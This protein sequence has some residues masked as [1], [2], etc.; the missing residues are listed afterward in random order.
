MFY[1]KAKKNIKF[2]ILLCERLIDEYETEKT[3][4]PSCKNDVIEEISKLLN[5]SKKELNEWEADINH[6]RIA[7]SLLANTCYDLLASGNYHIYTGM[8]NPMKCGS[9]M[10]KVYLR[11]MDYA[12]KTNEI[13]EQEKIEQITMLKEQMSSVG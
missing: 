1:F 7:H 3:A 10:M 9:R 2:M 11:C 13:T 5:R 6:I 8:L 4:A 12:V